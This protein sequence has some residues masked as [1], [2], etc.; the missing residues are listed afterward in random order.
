MDPDDAT[1]NGVRDHGS[2]SEGWDPI[3]DDGA[4]EEDSDSAAKRGPGRTRA[5]GR[6]RGGAEGR[7]RGR[8]KNPS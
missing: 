1:A 7:G 4:L 3:V 6:G 5:R 2:D 8:G